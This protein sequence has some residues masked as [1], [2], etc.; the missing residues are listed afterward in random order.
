MV[1]EKIRNSVQESYHQLTHKQAGFVPRKAQNFLVAEIVKTL[2][3]TEIKTRLL[4]AE[5]GTG[6][7]KSMAYAQGAIPCAHHLQKKL[8]ISTATLSLQEQ[9]LNKDLPL[10]QAISDIPFKYTLVKGRHRYCCAERLGALVSAQ[11]QQ[12]LPGFDALL[13]F[14]PTKPQQKLLKQLWQAYEEG[15]WQGDRDSWPQPIDDRLWSAICAERH[16]CN[17]MLPAHRECPLHKARAELLDSHVLIV[18]HALLLAD[19]AS[20]S[21]ILPPTDECFYVL[22]EAHH[23]ADIAREQAAAHCELRANLSWLNKLPQLGDKITKLVHNNRTRR[24]C[25]NINKLALDGKQLFGQL[26][27][28]VEAN[29]HWFADE[30]LCRFPLGRLPDLLA[31]LAAQLASLSLS[32]QRLLEQGETLLAEHF[33]ENGAISHPSLIPLLT[34]WGY[35]VERATQI[36]ELWRLY[37]AQEEKFPLAKWLER[38]ESQSEYLFRASPLAMGPWL[39]QVL[40]QRCAGAIMLSATLTALN[41]FSLFRRHT[42][43]REEDGTRFLRLASPFDYQRAELIVPRMPCDPSASH[44]TDL[45]IETLPEYL[46]EQKASLVLFASLKQM[47]DVANGLRQ[48]GFELLVQGEAS[49]DALLTQHALRCSGSGRSILFGSASFAEGV[50]LPGDLLTNLIIT[51]LPFAVPTSPIESAM[52]EWV[53]T[54]GGNP[55]LQL[56]LPDASRKLIQA[57]GRLIRKESD[58]GRVVILDNRVVTRHYGASLLAALPP[59]RRV[60]H[61]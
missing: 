21:G 20:G 52:A 48:R 14:A 11:N 40:W 8:V 49:R 37:N 39:Q 35:A 24:L 56:T 17:P 61:E 23:L 26:L 42:G 1:P 9:L 33:K 58:T 5:A 16:I 50:D 22:D 10:F 51:K 36:S 3:D 59:F 13:N 34:E 45:L 6:T 15:R 43:L 54:H 55:F 4:V 32:L 60:L 31:D 46:H 44:F 19:L 41:S 30:P 2:S 12:T 38:D 7:G 53:T 57:C 27:L 47:N 28:L 18:N 29:P 25:D